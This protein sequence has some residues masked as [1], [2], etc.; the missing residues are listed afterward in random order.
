METSLILTFARRNQLPAARLARSGPLLLAALLALAGCGGEQPK[1]AP[2]AQS[3]TAAPDTLV[4]ELQVGT[5]KPYR[6]VS[7]HS[8]LPIYFD[9]DFYYGTFP[10]KFV[11]FPVLLTA[12]EDKFIAASTPLVSF[13]AVRPIRVFLL[14]VAVMRSGTAGALWLNQQQGWE[15][16][17]W[18]IG[19]NKEP[20]TIVVSSRPYAAGE[21]VKLFGAGC[22]NN[23]CD[24]YGVLVT[25]EP[26]P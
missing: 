21:Q 6:W 16:E 4:K 18:K 26:L 7:F 19:T 23:D 1:S 10:E 20:A 9:R 2:P 11:G 5:G 25:P 22:T 14:H 3:F 17:R 12:N 8:G 24:N 13:T 15:E